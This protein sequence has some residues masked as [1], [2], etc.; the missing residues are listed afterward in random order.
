MIKALDNTKLSLASPIYSVFQSAYQVEAN[1]IGTLNFPPLSRSV[2]DIQKSLTHFYGFYVDEVLAGVIEVTVE[3]NRLHINSLTVAPSYFK[4]GIA[5][6]LIR[7][8]LATFNF[9]QAT[10]ETA[11]VNAPAIALYQK[12]GFVEFKRYTPDHGIEKTAME[13]NHT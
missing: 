8:A 13:L 11:V 1:L 2:E 9:A 5:S 10:V 6:Q 3:S 12:H 7:Y 4:Q